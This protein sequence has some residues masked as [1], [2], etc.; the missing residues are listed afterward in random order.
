MDDSPQYYSPPPAHEQHLQKMIVFLGVF[1]VGLAILVGGFIYF[2]PRILV[3]LPIEA[4]QRFVKPYE[5]LTGYWQQKYGEEATEERLNIEHYLQTL[6]NELG[7]ASDL[8]AGMQLKVHLINSDAVN[9]FATLGGHVFVCR[10]LMESVAD[11]NGLSMVL[12]HEIAHI[13]HRDPVVGMSRGLALQ[14]I[15]SFV[16]GDYSRGSD[17]VFYGGDL[18]LLYF[19]REQ[20]SNADVQALSALHRHYGHIRGHTQIFEILSEAQEE[21]GVSDADSESA[22]LDWLSS[23]PD[24][25]DRIDVLNQQATDNQW[26]QGPSTPV[27]TEVA[28]WL[29]EL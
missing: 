10:G 28:A 4:E 14:L 17:W 13:K 29:E 19:S 5:Q 21:E 25:T 23:H 18:G 1:F 20:E 15:Y 22:S 11:E 12:A 6:S 8:P 26:R 27:P 9:A 2:A 16:T 3:H 24:L 7:E